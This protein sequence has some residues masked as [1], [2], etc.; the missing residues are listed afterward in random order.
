M[1]DNE[2]LSTEEEKVNNPEEA[3][4]NDAAPE[5]ETAEEVPADDADL[6]E[7]KKS[8]KKK[9]RGLEK[10]VAELEGKLSEN[11]K[12]VAELNDKY[13][14][15][16]AEYDNFRRRSAKEREGVYTDAYAEAVK[17]LLPIIDN[18]ERAASMAG[19]SGFSEGLAIIMRSANDALAKMG[20]TEIECKEFDPN[21]HNAVMHIEDESCGENQIVEVLQ[22]GYMR[23]DRVIRYAMVKVAN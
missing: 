11:E 1:N 2:T 18:L 3:A 7:K 6:E 20:I 16:Y 10:Q 12:I 13:L 17:Y 14:R 5:T 21:F 8:A 22:K 19:D 4:E 23:G 15:L 9:I